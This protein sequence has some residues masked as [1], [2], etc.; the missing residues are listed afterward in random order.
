MQSHSDPDDAEFLEAMELN[1]RQLTPEQEQRFEGYIAEIFSA[2]GM[3]LETPSTRDTPRRF[4]R[5]LFEATDG[6]DGDPKLLKVFQTECFSG[7]ECHISQVV[8]GPINFFSLCEHH[9]FPFFGH[10]Y[11]GYIAHEE[12]L[13]I[14][15]LTRLVRVFARRFAVQERIG[16]AGCRRAGDD[17]AP[18]RGGGVPGS[19]PPVHGDARRARGGADDPHHGV[20]RHVR[21]RSHPAGGVLHRLRLATLTR[22]AIPPQDSPSFERSCKYPR[23]F[24][25]P[26]TEECTIILVQILDLYP[27]MYYNIN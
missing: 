8:E 18:A 17:A 22:R 16:S 1:C 20:A 9:A 7:D 24:Q 23:A 26:P 2:Y 6:Y 15:K 11:V 21:R 4:I 25:A 10:A 12:I 27:I 3:D 5:A 13:G 19:A 14:S